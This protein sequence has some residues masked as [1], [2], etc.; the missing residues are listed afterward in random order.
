MG[1]V[2]EGPDDTIHSWRVTNTPQLSPD[3]LYDE[4][5]RAGVEMDS[6]ESDL[7]VP[8]TDAVRALLKRYRFR[9]GCV[10][11]TD[12]KTNTLWVTIPFAFKPFW[13]NR[14]ERG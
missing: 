1:S 3:Q 8:F 10:P 11:F 2:N 5:V 6:H 12:P 13:A 7:Y 14:Q 9:Q 4:L